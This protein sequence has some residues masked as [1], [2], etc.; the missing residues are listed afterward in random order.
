[1]KISIVIP[2]YNEEKYIGKTL[3]SVKQLDTDGWEV[4]IIIVDAGS[5]DKT[6]QIA[7]TFGAKVVIIPHRGI[8]FARQKGIEHAAGEIIAFTDADTIVA[9]NWLSLHVRALA[10]PGVVL[11]YGPFKVS[12][13]SF[14]YYHYVNYIQF[15][16][17]WIIHYLFGLAFA[18][19]QNMAFWRDKA[20]SVGGFNTQL[21][22]LEDNDFSLRMAKIGKVVFLKDAVVYSSGRRSKEGLGFFVRTT[23]AVVKYY[24]LR[25]KN[26]QRFPDFR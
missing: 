2:T 15:Y 19:G 6:A 21:P 17:W 16:A 20:K 12:D 11:T 18:A 9:E 8:G 10:K 1:M 24:F 22:I 7:K 13:G 26:L 23:V 3:K 25:Q 4:E 5:T 14:P